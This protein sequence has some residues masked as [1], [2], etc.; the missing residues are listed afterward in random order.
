MLWRW[1]LAVCGSL[2]AINTGKPSSM[3][4]GAVTGGTTALACRPCR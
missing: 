2:H 4:G 3:A 1:Q